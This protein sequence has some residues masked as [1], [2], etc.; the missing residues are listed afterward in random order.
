MYRNKTFLAI[1]PARDGSKG[2]PNKNIKI[3]AGR[4]MIF[5]TIKAARHCRGKQNG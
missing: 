5:W 2:L 4:P 1:I 3:M